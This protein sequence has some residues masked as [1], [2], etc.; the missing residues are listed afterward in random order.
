[1]A[2]KKKKSSILILITIIIL[3]L[4]Y[5][6]YDDIYNTIKNKIYTETKKSISRYN[7]NE[8]GNWIDED[9]DGL[10]TRNEVLARESLIKPIISND[11]VISGKW[12]D[13]FTGKYFNN[14]RDLDIDHLIPLK[15][16]Y[17]SGASNWSKKKKNQYYNY[18]KNENHLIAVSRGANRSK[19]DKSPIEWLPPNKE[20]QCEYVREWYKIK[21]Y[22]GLTI[23]DGFNEV[24]NIVCKGK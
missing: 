6:Y 5:S 11:K 24:S 10:N 2:R 22:W 4:V 20:Y 14:P 17:M 9:N 18:L 12:Y 15:N 13:K 7:R 3:T 16:A 23:E 8:W 1:M 21:T 19:S